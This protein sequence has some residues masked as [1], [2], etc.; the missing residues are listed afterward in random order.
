MSEAVTVAEATRLLDTTQAAVGSV[1]DQNAV[2]RLPLAIRNWDD[3]LVLVPG[4]QGDRYT[5]GE[6]RHRRRPHRRRQRARQPLAAEQL[7]ARR[8]RQ[9]LDLDQRP[10]ADHAGLAPL[11]R[12][13]RGV[14]GRDQP[15]LRRVRARAGRRDLGHHQVRHQ[16]VPRHRLLL[17]PRRE[18]STR[19][20]TSTRTSA[21]SATSRR[22]PSRATTRTSS[23]STSAARS[24]RTGSSSSPTTRARAS[25]AAPR[26]SRACR[27]STSARA[28]SAARVRDPLTGQ[29]FPGNIIPASR[30]D[31]VA[32][33]DLRPAARAQHDR[34]QQLH[35]ARRQRHRRRRPLHR[36]ASTSAPRTATP[37][38]RATST[39]T[40]SASLP[41]VFGGMIDGTGTSAFGDQTI[42]SNGLVLGW[43]RIFGPSVVN[44]F[45]FS[46][47]RRRFGRGPA[48]LRP[49]AA[50][51]G[52]RC[53]ACPTTRSSAG[54]V[55]GMTIDGYFGGGGLGRMGS[56]N[57]L[58]EV[59]AHEPVGVPE[60]AVLAQ[61][62]P[63]V[64]VRGRRD[65]A[66]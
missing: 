2:A 13:D 48:A 39:P 51:R 9:Q 3:L 65:G 33:G 26:A 5:R 46:W 64:Q 10:G 18:A 32:A 61:G 21:P 58:A 60:H 45:R 31:P 6:R 27:R 4:V 20:P 12:R 15:L 47:S 24:S 44:E 37:S 29:P 42:N 11:D 66:R 17:L 50:A 63:P 16:R 1:I 55:I 43:T 40:A 8:R 53:R 38:S 23:A 56:P 41:G 35:P 62:R 28:S 52:A 34:H 49:G 14:Q 7:P 22:C 57:F 36:Q 25:P 30:I 59:P 19:T 54:G